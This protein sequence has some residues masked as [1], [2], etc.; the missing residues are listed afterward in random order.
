MLTLHCL[1]TLPYLT[2][3]SLLHR[4]FSLNY[5]T[6]LHPTI[7]PI[8]HTLSPPPPPPPLP[9]PPPPHWTLVWLAWD[10]SIDLCL[11]LSTLSFSHPSPPFPLSSPPLPSLLPP[12]PSSPLSLRSPP[13]RGCEYCKQV[14]LNWWAAKKI[15][16]L[17]PEQQ[18]RL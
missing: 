11:N 12:L 13:Q 2:H 14:Q 6:T 5:C 3:T 8:S 1:P 18:V 15:E 7:P 17:T 9:P 16:Q 10:V 4:L